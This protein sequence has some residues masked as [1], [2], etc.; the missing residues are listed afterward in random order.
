MRVERGVTILARDGTRLAC[1]VYL[2]E[3]PGRYPALLSYSHYGKDL[4]RVTGERAPL[5]PLIG[6]GGLEAGDSEYFVSRGYVHVI[7]DARGSGD[8]EGEYCYQGPKEQED[9]YDIIEWMA[10]QEWCDGNCGMLG[11]SYFAVMQY[12][13]AAQQ[14]P[15]LKAIVP[16]EA[17]TDRYRQSTYHGGLLNEGFWHQWWGHVS[18]DGMRPLSFD[19]LDQKEIDRRVAALMETPE[20]QRSP[21]L[22]IQLKY[23]NKNPLLFSWLLEPLD[24]PFYWERSPYRMFDRIK[25]PTFLVTR[26]TSWA[27]HLAG[28]FEA[29]EG[30]DAPKKLLIMETASRLGPLRPWSDHHDLILRWY[31]HWLKGIDTGFMDEPPIRILVKGKDEYR[32]E[33]EWPLKR[34]EWTRMYLG[35]SGT[36]TLRNPDQEGQASFVNEPNLPPGQHATGLAFESAPFEADVEMTGPVALYLQG[37]L[38]QPDA[39]WVVTVR[40]VAPDGTSRTITKG[41]LRASQRELDPEKTKDYRP[42]QKHLR[43]ENL[44]VGKAYAY[45]IEIREMSNVFLRGHRI[46]LDIKGQDTTAEDPIWV[47]T[48][49]AVATTHTVQFG[50]ASEAFLLLPFIP[51]K[52]E[53]K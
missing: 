45:A 48:C 22:H 41:W 15:H 29:Y 8:S 52:G 37:R 53:K 42:Y 1:D 33:H 16:Y 4:Q 14:P 27:V 30:I 18:V 28:A 46:A 13:V 20:V 9:G 44:V 17:L 51:S 38:D 23:P 5:S 34:T 36:L 6:N 7:A 3:V 10:A 50:G 19:Y 2:P 49:N 24:G 12:L 39:T 43:R 26:W 31:D 40:D 47:H 32:D 11:M 35:E 21:Y 25:I